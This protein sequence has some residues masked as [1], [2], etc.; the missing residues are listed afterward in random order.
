MVHFPVRY[1]KLPEGMANS[2]DLGG[3]SIVTEFYFKVFKR[4]LVLERGVLGD[5]I[6]LH[7]TQASLGAV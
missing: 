6:D 3:I 2:Y 7:Q 1:V 5:C 4:C